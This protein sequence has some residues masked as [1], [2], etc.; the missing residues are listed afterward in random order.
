MFSLN[1]DEPMTLAWLN[2]PFLE[3]IQLH[4]LAT[5]YALQVSVSR[6]SCV[7]REILDEEA[8]RLRHIYIYTMVPPPCT[9]G[10]L[11]W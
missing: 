5:K 8:I 2:M 1:Q 11:G 9:D 4:S 7:T 10:V 6:G 3:A